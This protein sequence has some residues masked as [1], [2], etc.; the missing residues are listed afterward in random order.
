M[1]YY[2]YD[3]IRIYHGDSRDILPG[4]AA[5]IMVTDPPYGMNYVVKDGGKFGNQRVEGDES[6]EARDAV[7]AIWAPRPAIVFGRWS[8]PKPAATKHTLI[9]DKGD[10]PG[11]GDLALP[12]GPSFEEIYIL[13]T[14]FIGKRGGSVLRYQRLTGDAPE[15]IH[16]TQKPISLMRA[17]IAN[18]PPDAVIVDPFMGGGTTLRAAKDLNRTA[19]GI[20]TDETYCA[21]VAQRLGQGVLDLGA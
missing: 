5:D 18:C 9:W 20:E 16:P 8:V 3:G 17:L 6:P 4:L 10:S 13:G 1:L 19:I 12:W 7:L 2:D 21:R 11:L 15:R 14:G